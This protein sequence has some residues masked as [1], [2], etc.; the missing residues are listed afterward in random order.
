MRPGPQPLNSTPLDPAGEEGPEPSQGAPTPKA[1]T[2]RSIAYST[3]RER[4]RTARQKCSCCKTRCRIKQLE[5]RRQCTFCIMGQ[6]VNGTSE[7]N[8]W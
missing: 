2:R 3:V 7:L 8:P 6:Q 1:L 5:P 4:T